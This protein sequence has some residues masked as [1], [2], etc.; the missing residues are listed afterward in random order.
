MCSLVLR[1]NY[2]IF[3]ENVQKNQEKIMTN[4]VKLTNPTPFHA[5]IQKVLSGEG[6]N[7]DVCLVDEGREDPN[8]TKSGPS[9]ARQRIAI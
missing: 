7:S 3:M 8:T 9:S 4:Q 5:S 6:S 1:Q 2:F